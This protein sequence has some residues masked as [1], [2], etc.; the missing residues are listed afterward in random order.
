METKQ[1]SSAQIGI[2]RRALVLARE[3]EVPEQ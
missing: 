3:D 1:Q 2:E